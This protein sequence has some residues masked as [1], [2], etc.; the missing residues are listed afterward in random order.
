MY[1]EIKTKP[2]KNVLVV[3]DEK[4]LARALQLKLT[5]SGHQVSVAYDGQEALNFLKEKNFDIMI[6]DLVMP[7][8]NGFGVLEALI[9]DTSLKKPKDILILSNLSQTEDK[10][11]ALSL[12]VL[13]ENFLTKSSTPLSQIVEIVEKWTPKK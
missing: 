9:A 11:K 10:E 3:E 6:L 7:I 4:P 12:G 8:I 2:P 1:S 13:P 5:S